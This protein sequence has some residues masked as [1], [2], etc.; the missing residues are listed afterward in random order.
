MLCCIIML[1]SSDPDLFSKS[2]PFLE[3]FRINDDGTEQLVHRTEVV[4][5]K[6]N[7]KNSGVVILSDLKV[8]P[9]GN[10]PLFF[11][12]SSTESTPS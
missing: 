4:N 12:F 10:V 9:D 7:Y 2:D 8:L 11:P 1:T 6:R 5:K 3:I